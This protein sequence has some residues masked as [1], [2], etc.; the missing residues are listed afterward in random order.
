MTAPVYENTDVFAYGLD[1][2][3]PLRPL[4][5]EFLFPP[6]ASGAPAIYLAGNSLGLQ[7]RKARKYVQMEMEDWER[8]GVEG[9]VH[10]RHPWLPYHEQLTDMVARVVGA[11]PQEVVVMNTLSVNLHLMMV[12][13]YRPTRERFKILIE[14][15]AFPSDQYAVASQARFHGYDPKEAIVRLM[16]REGEDTL[17][18]EDILET[19][20]RHGKE[21]A[22]VM[23]GSVNYL[24]G[25]AFDLRE[26]TRVAHAQGCKVGFDLA[27]GAGN[28][29][30][31]LHDDG[32]DFAVWCSYKYLNGG[33]GSLGGVFVHERH[34]H[35]PELPRFEGWWGHNKAT[36]FEMGPTFDPLPGAEGWQL[37][38]PPI[39]QL[40]ALRS[41]LEL[42]DRATMAALREKSDQ[43]TGYLEFLL[44]RL[45][46]GY[47]TITTPRDLKQRGAQ[48]SLRFKGEPKRLLQRLSAAGIICDFREP[49]IIRA[50]PAPLYNTYLDVFRFVKALEAHALE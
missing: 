41:S 25:Q 5:D 7:P 8:L 37:S 39:F 29:K 47:V 2:A 19:I 44:D 18:S 1:A 9:H 4:R 34:A 33:P 21:L 14:G 15:G 27:H 20:E 40:A 12:S 10:G 13:F 16:P 35:S 49:D 48:L 31:S 36:R 45:P 46:A 43:M 42:F 22:L 6:A 23:L 11:Q 17:R 50:A 32:P 24:T 30:L 26:I 38:N 28:L 3:D